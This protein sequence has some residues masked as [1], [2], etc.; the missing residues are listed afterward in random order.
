MTP[1]EHHDGGSELFL[2]LDSDRISSRAT[3]A[4]GSFVV[5]SKD[6]SIPRSESQILTCR[7]RCRHVVSIDREAQV[8]E[9]KD[10]MDG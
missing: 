10:N 1:Y 6:K 5:G 7:S 2:G 4:Q 8:S 3:G 9:L